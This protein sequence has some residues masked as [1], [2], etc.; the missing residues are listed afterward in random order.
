MA[1]RF[2]FWYE[3]CEQIELDNRNMIVRTTVSGVALVL[4]LGLTGCSTIDWIGAGRNSLAAFCEGQ[5]N[6][7]N[8]CPD[9]SETGIKVPRCNYRAAN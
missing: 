8:I 7:Q 6:C 1:A 2:S 3:F 4:V 9:G 5:K